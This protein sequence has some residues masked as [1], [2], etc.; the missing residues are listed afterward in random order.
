MMYSRKEKVFILI[1]TILCLINLIL[2]SA[3]NLVVDFGWTK[4]YLARYTY[5]LANPLYVLWCF[6]ASILL[7]IIT[8]KGLF[9]IYIHKTGEKKRVYYI[10][11][12]VL[13]VYIVLYWPYH[14]PY[15]GGL[16]LWIIVDFTG[17]ILLLFYM[18]YIFQ[19]SKK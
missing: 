9:K 7:F 18:I 3:F 15:R 17:I 6:E 13:L 8:A 12:V 1:L 11:L 14:I 19:P 2:N 5:K 4:D 10:S 16:D